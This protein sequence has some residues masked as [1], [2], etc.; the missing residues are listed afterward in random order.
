MRSVNTRPPAFGIEPGAQFSRP[1]Q[2]HERDVPPLRR[3]HGSLVPVAP[4]SVPLQVERDQRFAGV[5]D[6]E[7]RPEALAIRPPEQL[8]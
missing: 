5:P 4:L 7:L 6:L 3:G 8:A 1:A 2:P